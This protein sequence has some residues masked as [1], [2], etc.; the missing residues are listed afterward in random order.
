MHKHKLFGISSE[1]SFCSSWRKGNEPT[2]TNAP[3]EDE[4]VETVLGMNQKH[5]LPNQKLL[6]FS[7]SFL[8]QNVSLLPNSL[9]PTSPDFRFIP[10]SQLGSCWSR[11][12]A[13]EWMEREQNHD[14]TLEARA[15]PRQRTWSRPTNSIIRAPIVKAQERQKWDLGRT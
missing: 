7:I 12:K 5:I 11:S 15:Q 6:V 8:P 4:A 9:P 2:T 14:N 3:I 13:L 1:E 10:S